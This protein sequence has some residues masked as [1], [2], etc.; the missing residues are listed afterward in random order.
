VSAT[1]GGIVTVLLVLYLLQAAFMFLVA[2]RL[3]GLPLEADWVQTLIYGLAAG[4]LMSRQ[5]R[6]SAGQA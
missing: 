5:Q 6:A 2:F 1:L 4:Y 3:Y